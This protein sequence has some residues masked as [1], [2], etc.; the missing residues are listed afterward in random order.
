MKCGYVAVLGLPNA[1]KSSLTNF[2]VGEEV[3]IVSH[4]KQT[5]RNSILGIL[6]G[7]G[8]Q[9]IFVDTPGIHH[10]KNQL[11]KYMM[12]NV[13]GAI[14]EADVVLYLFDASKEMEA[15]EF[16]YIENLKTK[17]ENLILVATKIDKKCVGQRIEPDFEISVKTCEGTKEL[18]DRLVSLLPEREALFDED[19]YTDKS[20]KFL[21]SE[22]IREFLLEHLDKEIPHG[23]AVDIVS[24]LEDD[25]RVLIEADIICEREQHKGIVV[26]N[27][28]QNLKELGIFVRSYVENLL[29]K[30]CVLKFFVKVDK[31][32]RDKNISQYGY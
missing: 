23:I 4:R 2:L 7:N 27:G 12:K 19:L 32:W 9:I 3:A 15:E 18:L 21:V 25:E 6:N 22:K 14:A 31:D 17:T 13:R 10:S 16:E 29:D 26:G 1:G 20:I 8:F 5:T 11:D 30:K 24:F 28:G